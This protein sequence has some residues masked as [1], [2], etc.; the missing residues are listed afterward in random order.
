MSH[1]ETGI[2]VLKPFDRVAT[3]MLKESCS[4]ASGNDHNNNQQHLC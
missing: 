2:E 4:F 3:H 1:L